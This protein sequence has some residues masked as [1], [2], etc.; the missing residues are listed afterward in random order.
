M[1]SFSLLFEDAQ[2][3]VAALI[4]SLR[5]P[6]WHAL[7]RDDRLCL[8]AWLRHALVNRAALAAHRGYLQGLLRGQE[9]LVPSLAPD[10]ME[11]AVS[12]GLE[13]LT[14]EELGT[15]ALSAEALIFL[16]GTIQRDLPGA[17]LGA[18]IEDGEAVVQT[19]GACAPEALAGEE[20]CPEVWLDDEL[21]YEEGLASAPA[22]DEPQAPAQGPI[23]TRLVVD[24]PEALRPLLTARWKPASAVALPRPAALAWLEHVLVNRDALHSHTRFVGE[25]APPGQ[26]LSEAQRQV[27]LRGGPGELSD[28]ALTSLLFDV[29]TLRE[30]YRAIESELPTA[31]LEAM[32][33][34]GEALLERRRNPAPTPVPV[35]ILV[36]ASLHRSVKPY[37]L[38]GAAAG[39]GQGEEQVWT[40]T[41]PQ[42]DESI[43]LPPELAEEVY[44]RPEQAVKLRLHARSAPDAPGHLEPLLEVEPAPPCAALSL[45]VTF[46]GGV[47]CRLVV[48]RV[49]GPAVL[50]APGAALPGTAFGEHN[51]QLSLEATQTP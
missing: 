2:P 12:Q 39:M 29:E 19:R 41:T 18:M 34:D 44:G 31:W 48:P 5:P 22:L 38:R 40:L 1:N 7:G 15:L 6:H 46:L 9:R 47:T 35:R 45:L 36:L 3:V 17:W 27:L 20:V 24:V 14:E 23:P 26:R 37:L 28:Q 10:S 11:R 33:R 51:W 30:L 42:G 32:A 8:Q 21:L 49:E 4:R 43:P 16:H 13:A 25:E 50:S